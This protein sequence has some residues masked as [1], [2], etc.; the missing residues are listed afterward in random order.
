M[1]LCIWSGAVCCSLNRNQTLFSTF[2]INMK[3]FERCYVCYS[4]N[5][6]FSFIPLY[7]SKDLIF[8][9]CFDILVPKHLEV[10]HSIRWEGFKWRQQA[11][12]WYFPSGHG[13]NAWSDCVTT[14]FYCT[15]S[16]AQDAVG[17][18]TLHWSL[19]CHL[20]TAMCTWTK[21]GY[22]LQKTLFYPLRILYK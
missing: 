14:T 15:I 13:W 17:K 20:N 22:C 19:H 8:V 10:S 5:Y 7:T 18:S 21:H 12:C 9:W 6:S 1:L 4:L 16:H 11:H 2:Q 3:L